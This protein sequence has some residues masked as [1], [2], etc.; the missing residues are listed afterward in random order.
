VGTRTLRPDLSP[1]DEALHT[2][3]PSGIELE[4]VPVL[5]SPH[6][7]FSPDTGTPARGAGCR[8]V[9]AGGDAPS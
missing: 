2:A 9:T 5:L 7:L 3:A 4:E 8:V 1:L 6:V